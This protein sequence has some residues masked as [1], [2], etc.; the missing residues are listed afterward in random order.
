[1]KKGY[2]LSVIVPIY[3]ADE[4]LERCLKSITTQTFQNLEII[5]VNDGSTDNSINIC[6]KYCEV[7]ERIRI[8][9]KKNAGV[10]A[11]RKDAIKIA[12]GDFITF[13]DADDYIDNNMYKSLMEIIET[14]SCDIIES[15]YILIN[16]HEEV[17]DRRV[18]ISENNE[19]TNQCLE[20]Y[21]SNKNSEA[22]LWNKIYRR[23][24][25]G[26]VDYPELK[27]SEDYLW[28][29]IFYSRCKKSITVDLA[30]YYY[31]KN[32]NGACNNSNYR[33]KV[34]GIV[35]GGMARDYLLSCVPTLSYYGVL[36]SIDYA[37]FLYMVEFEL[38]VSDKE[39]Y[40]EL[41]K[42]FREYFSLPLICKKR[43]LKKIPGYLLFYWMP[44]TYALLNSF[45]HKMKG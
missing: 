32:M 33:Q 1:M 8:I 36:Y 44:R 25:F 20:A 27:Y 9:D 40:R 7:D 19:G 14:E 38:N 30:Y 5:L 12:T 42:Y 6:K 17:I 3:N 11:A 2:K 23:E 31:Y 35:A 43:P 16:E 34:D 18:L 24:L 21:L 26:D 13:V 45:Y 39:F 41:I 29:V 22:F 10:S 4:L 28:N 15:G 37:R